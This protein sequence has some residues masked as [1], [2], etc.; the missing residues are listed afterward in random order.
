MKKKMPKLQKKNHQRRR[1]PPK[2]T[3]YSSGEIRPI[4]PKPPPKNHCPR[5][6]KKKKKKSLP[7]VKSKLKKEKKKEK[8]ENK[9]KKDKVKAFAAV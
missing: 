2:I 7:I 4:C 5:F 8:K 9:I 6:S 1:N 3:A